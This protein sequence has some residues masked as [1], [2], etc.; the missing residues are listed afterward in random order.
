M[1]PRY[2]EHRKEEFKSMLTR[3]AIRERLVKV[4]AILSHGDNRRHQKETDT[5]RNS[6]LM[7]LM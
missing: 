5:N 4:I 6:V 3:N 7:T 1:K 2:S